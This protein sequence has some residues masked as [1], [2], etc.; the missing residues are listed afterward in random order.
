MNRSRRLSRLAPLALALALLL[1]LTACGPGGGDASPA[2]TGPAAEPVE[3]AALGI[4][5]DPPGGAGFELAVNQGETLR[6]V[7][8]ASSDGEPAELTFDVWLQDGNPNLVAAV[9]QQQEDVDGRPGGNFL[10]QVQLGS[11]LGTAYSTRGR[12]TGD[13]GREMEEIRVFAVHP[14]GD[15]LLAMTYRYHPT[16]G[17]SKQRTEEAMG[18]LGLVQPQPVGELAPNLAGEPAADEADGGE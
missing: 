13:D 10:G 14:A 1:P 16:A 7:H 6:L 4:A 5:L 9:N 11:Q 15:R 2:P 12:Y 17:A 8:S 18:A 3:N